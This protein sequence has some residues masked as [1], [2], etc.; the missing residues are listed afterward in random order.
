MLDFGKHSR[1]SFAVFRCY[2]IKQDSQQYF[3]FGWQ[4]GLF[5]Q[6][7]DQLVFAVQGIAN[8]IVIES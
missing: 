6:A 3:V 7:D 5:T 1:S 4:F 2:Q 8:Y